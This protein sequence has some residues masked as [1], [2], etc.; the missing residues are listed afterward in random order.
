MIAAFDLKSETNLWS[1]DHCTVTLPYMVHFGPVNDA[2]ELYTCHM[3]CFLSSTQLSTYWH[4]LANVNIASAIAAAA[5]GSAVTIVASVEM[6]L[7]QS[8]FYI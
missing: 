2:D 6:Y 5:F 4:P 1:T 7:F 3:S 8:P